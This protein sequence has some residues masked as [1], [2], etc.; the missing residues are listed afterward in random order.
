MGLQCHAEGSH[1]VT[2]VVFDTESALRRSRFHNNEEVKMAVH[3]GL[4]IQKPN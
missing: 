2:D 1:L 4:Q 3:E